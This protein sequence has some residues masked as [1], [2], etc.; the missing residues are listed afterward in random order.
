MAGRHPADNLSS[1]RVSV[2][3]FLVAVLEDAF[4]EGLILWL[5][6][7]VTE[8]EKANNILAYDALV[9]QVENW[10]YKG[11][12]RI[13]FF[14]QED[15]EHSRSRTT[16]QLT[17]CVAADFA[18]PHKKA[19]RLIASNVFIAVNTSANTT[20]RGLGASTHVAEDAAAARAAPKSRETVDVFVYDLR[21]AEGLQ[22]LQEYHEEKTRIRSRRGFVWLLDMLVKEGA[23][24]FPPLS[25][26]RTGL[27]CP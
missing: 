12:L 8:A 11:K 24:P 26:G 4:K 27:N 6:T 2:A 1:G 22:K 21:S 14:H 23:S 15:C 19:L 17:I 25:L 10:G 16:R 7:C 3:R 13:Y 9:R 5:G 18:S 20:D